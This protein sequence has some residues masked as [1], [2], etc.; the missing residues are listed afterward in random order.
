MDLIWLCLISVRCR[1][2]GLCLEFSVWWRF[3]MVVCMSFELNVTA[4]MAGCR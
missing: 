2:V 1:I 4:L 3:S